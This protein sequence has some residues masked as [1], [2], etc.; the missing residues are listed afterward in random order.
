MYIYL[1][2]YIYVNIDLHVYIYMTR[3]YINPSYVGAK[4]EDFMG[5]LTHPHFLQIYFDVLPCYPSHVTYAWY[6]DGIIIWLNF[7][8]ALTWK[9]QETEISHRRV[10]IS[11]GFHRWGYPK[12][13]HFILGFSLTK[14]IQLLGYPHDYGN[15][16]L[17]V[18]THVT[19]F[20]ISSSRTW[21]RAAHLHDSPFPVKK[22]RCKL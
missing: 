22:Q 11:G 14:T 20:S 5:E 2:I 15:L 12:I 13:I 7:K 9:K 10:L 1:Y 19:V 16:H 18:L 3:W 6:P 21:D 17:I 8:K 4:T